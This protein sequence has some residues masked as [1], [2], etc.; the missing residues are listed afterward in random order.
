MQ[1]K[2]LGASPQ[3]IDKLYANDS[4]TKKKAPQLK[5]RLVTFLSSKF[6]LWSHKCVTKRPSI[7]MDYKQCDCCVF[8]CCC[9]ASLMP[10]HK[11]MTSLSCFDKKRRPEVSR[12]TERR[13]TSNEMK[14]EL[15]RIWC[16]DDSDSELIRDAPAFSLHCIKLSRYRSETS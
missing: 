15:S 9:V 16:G 2:I 5:Q 14:R 12:A 11:N 10:F 1:R 6:W 7:N 13:T 3:T 8:I 4:R